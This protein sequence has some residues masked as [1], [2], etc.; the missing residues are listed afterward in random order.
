M[1]D[2]SSR[3]SLEEARKAR[4]EAAAEASRAVGDLTRRAQEAVHER[5]D[6]I[7]GPARDYTELAGERFDEAQ[8]YLV[9]KINEKPIQAAVTAL[10]VG[11]VIGFLLAGGRGR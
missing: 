5:L 8:R 7:G 2:T 4:A 1:P 9:D 11:V 3:L 10:G 6:G